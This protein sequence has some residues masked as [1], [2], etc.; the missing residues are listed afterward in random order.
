MENNKQLKMTIFESGV[1]E[2][3]VLYQATKEEITK[4][5][6]AQV[7]DL[8]P[9]EWREYENDLGIQFSTV[10]DT[11]ERDPYGWTQNSI[12]GNSPVEIPRQCIL[13]FSKKGDKILDPFCGSGTSLIVSAHLERIGTAVEVNPKIIEIAK[14]NLYSAQIP[15]DKPFLHESIA[16]QT[17]VQGDSTKLLDLGFEKKSF[18]FCF[19]HPPYGELVKYSE[20]YGFAQGDLSNETTLEGFLIGI[21][22]VFRGVF[23]LLKP[24]KFFCVLIGEDFK[25]GGKTI[26]LDYYLTSSGINSGFDF[27][28]KII[29]ITRSASSRKNNENIMKFRSIRSNF[30]ICNHDYVLIFKK[31]KTYD[32]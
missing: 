24:G 21:E 5:E 25:T 7:N 9:R 10:W 1:A 8:D 23:E 16:K 30:F 12:H 19:A 22:R 6:N 26:P 20:E 2:P 15:F 27:F 29:K 11:P 17:I 28:A 18:D 31:S 3:T 4:S 14:R 13:R 32:S